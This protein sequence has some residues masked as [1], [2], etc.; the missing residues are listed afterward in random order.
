VV[1]EL[2]N[3]SGQVLLC[4]YPGWRMWRGI[5]GLVYARLLRSSP[6]VIVRAGGPD[7]ESETLDKIE[8]WYEEHPHSRPRVPAL[9]PPWQSPGRAS[10]G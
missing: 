6:P 10:G 3:E 1:D 2:R 5:A 8:E 9:A 7:A 4:P